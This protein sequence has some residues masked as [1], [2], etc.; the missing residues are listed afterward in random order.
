MKKKL[1]IIKNKIQEMWHINHNYNLLLKD[2]K[3]KTKSMK[4]FS[5]KY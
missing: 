5:N 4:T 1:Q 3:S 2:K